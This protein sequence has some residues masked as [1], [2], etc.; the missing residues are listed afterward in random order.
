MAARRKRWI[1]LVGG[2]IAV[3]VAVVYALLIE[4]R[5][6][7]VETVEV[8]LDGWPEDA[9]A[10][11]V[12]LLADLHAGDRDGRWI[13]RIVQKTLE[14]KPEVVL[15]LG[16]Y[17]NAVNAGLSMPEEELAALLAPLTAQ[18]P[19]YYI[20]GN[21]DQFEQA[22]A[23]RKAFVRH[24]IQPVEGKDVTLSFNNGRQAVL[25]GV[26][27]RHEKESAGPMLRRLSRKK[28][29]PTLPL[30]A[31]TH[32]PYHSIHS[33]LW[34]ELTVTGHTH[35]GQFCWPGGYPIAVREPWT[36]ET[37]R[38]GLRRSYTGQWLYVSRGLG[39]SSF[40]ARSFCAPEITLLLLRGSGKALQLRG[41]RCD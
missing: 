33:P 13:K 25:R 38:A 21:H 40:P 11:R 22:R 12:V 19:V 1:A 10:A 20:C 36:R 14:Q 7:L 18:C 41:T 23:T 39:A 6:L 3:A 30:I 4:P 26:A 27:H 16:D 28:L 29:P 31:A 17:H 32:S 9:A 37:A 8:Q 5:R 35:G 34:A 2:L 15:L 24:G